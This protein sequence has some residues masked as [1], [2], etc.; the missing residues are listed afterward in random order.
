MKKYGIVLYR[1]EKYGIILYVDINL[2]AN[3]T[4]GVSSA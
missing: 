1:M 3:V 4:E 2:T